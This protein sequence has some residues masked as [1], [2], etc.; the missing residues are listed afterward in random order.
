MHANIFTLRRGASVFA[1]V[2]LAL[3]GVHSLA[4]PTPKLADAFPVFDSYIKVSGRSAS[5]TGD[6]A[7]YA[8]RFQTPDNG[9]YGIEALHFNNDVSKDTTLVLDGRALSGAEDYLG[10][11]L[12]TKNEVGSFEVGYKRF[13][14]FYDGIGGFFPVNNAWTAMNPEELHTDRAKFW[15]DVNIALPNQPVF[16]LRYTNEL[17][18]GQKDTTIWGDSDLTGIPIW[19]NSAKNPISANRKIIPSFIDLN[20]RQETLEASIKHTVGNTELE[21]SV[22][23]NRT[24]SLD[25]RYVDRYPGELKPYPAIPTNPLKLVPATMANN[26]IYGFDQ[27]GNKAK[28]WTYTGKF[29]TTLTDHLKMFGGFS[30]QDASADIAG[31]RQMIYYLRTKV[32]DV[33]AVG[34]FTANGRPPYSY[35]TIAGSTA[36]KVLTGNFGLTYKPAGDLFINLALKGEDLDMSGSN[37]VMYTNTLVSLTTGA[38]TNVPI[39]GPNNSQRTERSW[40]PELDVRYTGIK[41]L[42]LYGTVDYRYSPGDESGTSTGVTTGGGTVIPSVVSSYDNVRE[43][44]GHYK[45]GANWTACKFFTLRAELFYKDHVNKYT[46]YGPDL[47]GLYVMGYQFYGTK[48]TAIVKPLPTLTFTTRYVRQSGKMD[49]ESDTTALYDSMDSKNHLLGETVDWTPSNQFY[50]QANLNVV[51]ATMSTS[52]PR[53]GGAGN[54]TLHDSNNNYQNGSVV[55]GFVVAK[56]TDA[57]LQYTFYRTNNYEPGLST[58]VPYGSSVRESTVTLGLKH[59]LT[60]RMICHAKVGYFD[61]QSDTT[62]GHTNFRGPMGYLSLDYAL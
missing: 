28:V 19:S 17:R 27:Q 61:S 47:G 40:T 32:G 58:S 36:E 15:A 29:E 30:Y 3:C 45:F 11:L 31:N 55:A 34:G 54:D 20:E 51:F 50:V 53:A 1:S 35:N 10:K 38:K 16:H 24:D 23:N 60:D 8:K 21:F 33:S 26:H 4:D 12:L 44:H 41:D 46:G 18:N 42:S 48:L 62:G 56:A 2:A 25:T 39:D 9:S 49:T 14:T 37:H 52:Y 43:N 13:R 5:V 22:V 59:K 7:A 57:Q 6:A